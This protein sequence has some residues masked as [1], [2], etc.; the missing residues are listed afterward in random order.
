[1]TPYKK[2]LYYYPPRP[3][4][5]ITPLSLDEYDDGRFIAQ[6]KMNG[7]ACMIFMN[8]KEMKIYDRHGAEKS[9][10]IDGREIYRGKGW[11]VIC[12]EWLNKGK[13]DENKKKFNEKFIIWDIIVYN[14]EYLTGSSFPE[15]IKLLDELYGEEDYNSYLYE[16]NEDFYR[17]KTFDSGF[18]TLF[19]EIEAKFE[20]G[21]GL[22]EGV[23]LKMK[24]SRL[25]KG[26][27][28]KNNTF[29]LLKCRLSTKNYAF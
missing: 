20:D 23:V 4:N 26:I 27:S 12:G 15:R 21:N 3:E 1:M 13:F 11:M 17:V 14:G 5:K 24:Q 18:K 9:W 25:K 19:D 8:E 16:I 10:P 22:L 7:S 2:F 6:P 28:S 29:T